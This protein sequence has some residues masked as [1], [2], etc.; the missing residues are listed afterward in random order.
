MYLCPPLKDTD[1]NHLRSGLRVTKLWS[2]SLYLY[3]KI[4][5]SEQ[6]IYW[7]QHFDWKFFDYE[8]KIGTKSFY[9]CKTRSWDHETSIFCCW[10]LC[11]MYISTFNTM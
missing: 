6:C 10:P 2:T 7:T 4:I 11:C 5:Q 1:K 3:S 8:Y 9:D